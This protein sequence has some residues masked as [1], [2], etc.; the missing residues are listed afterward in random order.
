MAITSENNSGMVMPVSPMY[1]GGNGGFG[2]FGGDWGWI[3]LLLL[4]GWGNG[5]FGGFGGG[6]GNMM[7]GYDFPWLLNGQN[8]INNNVSDGFRTAQLQDSIT[9]V[10]DGI[11]SLSTQLCGCCGDMQ[12]AIAGT[13]QNISQT[14]NGIISAVNGA[15]NGITQQL[16]ANELASL[17]RSFAEQAANMQGFNSVNAGLA[18]AK[19]VEATEACA[20]RTAS[21]QNTRDIID[22]QTRGTQAILD[23]LCAL[24]LDGVKGQLAAAQ[25]ENVGLQN[26][27]NMAALRESQTAQNAFIQQ[28]FSNEVD[29]LYNRL[30]SCPI[31]TIPVYGNQRI[32]TCGNNGCGCGNNAFAN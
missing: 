9:S 19:Y 13:N 20:T 16:Y 25:R 11:S 4:C 7:L 26:Q 17:N 6:Y 15:Q 5:G 28:G 2:G 22:A 21:A 14:G 24:E 12:M 27:L 3:I 23:K 8:G 18:D 31:N 1:G 29:A 32:F 30:S 10:R